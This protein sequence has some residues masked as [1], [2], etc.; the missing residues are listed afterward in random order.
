VGVGDLV[1]VVD[2]ICFGMLLFTIAAGLALTFGIAGVLNLSHG[3][4]YLVGAYI[5]WALT[6][7]SWAGLAAAVAVAAVGGVA[8]GAGLS[9]LLRPLPD[10]LDQALATI[11]VALIGGYGL[12]RL[13]GA[14][15]LDVDPPHGL[16]GSIDL[17][18]RPYPA[19]RLAFIAV[20]AMLA[21]LMW[22][23]LARTRAGLLVRAGADDPGM[24]GLLGVEPARVHTAVLAAGTA[25]A[26]TAGVLGAPVLGPA[27]GLDHTILIWS[28]IIVVAGG[29]RSIPAS[30]AVALA[31]GQINTTALTA[32]PGG[33]PYLPY[34]ILIVALLARAH[35]A[36]RRA[37]AA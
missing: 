22:W 16:D 19:Y 4:F 30:L 27:P 2:G 35:G 34:A 11:G 37:R 33:A 36:R 25:L 15:P 1:V 14:D 32:W 17:A 8:A 3:V 7:A 9:V 24:L 6:G 21:A 26:T 23:V 20:A 5:G 13:F 29:L 12:T 18:G 28:L 10:H 31:L